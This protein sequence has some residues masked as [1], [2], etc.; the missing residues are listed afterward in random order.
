MFR[1]L[2]G[3]NA[4]DPDDCWPYLRNSEEEARSLHFTLLNQLWWGVGKE[5]ISL[6]LMRKDF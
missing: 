1:S 4:I 2:D 3:K 6:K 5:N